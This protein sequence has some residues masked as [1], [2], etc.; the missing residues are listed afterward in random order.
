MGFFYRLT[1]CT[2]VGID[3]NHVVF[4]I[5]VCL[6]DRAHECVGPEDERASEKK[7][8]VSKCTTASVISLDLRGVEIDS[9][10]ISTGHS[11]RCL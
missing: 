10:Y 3:Q 7:T 9:H 11:L 1:D 8:K 4:S 6:V 5:H 2:D